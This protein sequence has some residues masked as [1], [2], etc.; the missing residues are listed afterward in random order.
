MRVN[1]RS[2]PGG[3]RGCSGWSSRRTVTCRW[4][5]DALDALLGMLQQALMDAIETGW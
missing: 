5:V 1:A 2:G 4:K 3:L